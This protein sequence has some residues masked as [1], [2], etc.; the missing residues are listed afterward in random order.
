MLLL[1]FIFNQRFIC[2][3]KYFL[4]LI[5]LDEAYYSSNYIYSEDIVC[6]VLFLFYTLYIILERLDCFY[7]G[8]LL[9]SPELFT[10]KINWLSYQII[11][12]NITMNCRFEVSSIQPVVL[13]V[14][15]NKALV[16][17]LI[18]LHQ[19]N[20]EVL[21]LLINQNLVLRFQGTEH[22]ELV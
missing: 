10:I 11:N 20:A 9:I 1:K 3:V 15:Q 7:V 13:F 18:R 16:S 4:Y 6:L 14:L 8:P 21:Q 17:K 2:F 19:H 12:Q 5:Q 22:F